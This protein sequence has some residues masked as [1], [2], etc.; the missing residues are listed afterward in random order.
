MQFSQAH[1]AW[2][3]AWIFAGVRVSFVIAGGTF[4]E[5]VLR[6][7]FRTKSATCFRPSWVRSKPLRIIRVM[8][9]QRDAD[10]ICAGFLRAVLR[11]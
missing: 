6:R 9:F 5:A 1:C 3:C 7:V 8:N 2:F 4:Q 10:A 11:R